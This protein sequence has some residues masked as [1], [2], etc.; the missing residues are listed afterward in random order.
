MARK[1][2]H[3][4]LDRDPALLAC[5]CGQQINEMLSLLAGVSH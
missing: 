2:S 4:R 1:S 3:R 5:K